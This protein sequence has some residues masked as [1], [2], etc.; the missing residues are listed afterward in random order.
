MLSSEDFSDIFRT[1]EKT[2]NDTISPREGPLT[3]PANLW[4]Y[5]DLS[6]LVRPRELRVGYEP[7]THAGCLVSQ[8]C[9]VP[10][11]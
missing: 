6:D 8:V 5:R 9:R 11:S 3:D 7:R 10:S 4:P 1:I 2:H